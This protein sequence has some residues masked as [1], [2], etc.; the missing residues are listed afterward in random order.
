MCSI[1]SSNNRAE[2]AA[3]PG[4]FVAE[5]TAELNSVEWCQQTEITLHGTSVRDLCCNK[6]EFGFSRRVVS[7]RLCQ[8][9]VKTEFFAKNR[10]FS[11]SIYGSNTKKE[12]VWCKR[13]LQ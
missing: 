7:I 9:M 12:T 10:P 5:G 3:S 1:E 2:L 6:C 8:E 11:L 4:A 13:A